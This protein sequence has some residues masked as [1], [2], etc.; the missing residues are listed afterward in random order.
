MILYPTVDVFLIFPPC[1]AIE[2][3]RRTCS[4]DPYATLW[5]FADCYF[6]AKAFASNPENHASIADLANFWKGVG[7]NGSQEAHTAVFAPWRHDRMW[8]E[9]A[10]A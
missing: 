6:G 8:L 10:A 4:T 7:S 3:F 5:Q 2:N 1:K 9:V